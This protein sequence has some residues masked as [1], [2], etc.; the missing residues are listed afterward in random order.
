MTHQLFADKTLGTQGCD[1]TRKRM[2]ISTL[3]V[4]IEIFLQHN[5]RFCRQY[6]RLHA[7]RQTGCSIGL[8]LV[9][10]NPQGLTYSHTES[11]HG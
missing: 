11:D 2:R 1:R 10:Q 7:E 8:T 4:V 3:P 6:A 9:L 5:R